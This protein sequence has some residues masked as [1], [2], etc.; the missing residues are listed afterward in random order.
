M[1]DCPPPAHPGESRDPFFLSALIVII[2][3]KHRNNMFG[4]VDG[5]FWV[6][7]FAGMSGFVGEFPCNN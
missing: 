7:A 6:P 4:Y 2:S 1:S 5:D 3:A